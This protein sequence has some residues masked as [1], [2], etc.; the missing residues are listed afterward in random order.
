MEQDLKDLKLDIISPDAIVS[1]K[2]STGFYNKLQEV[3]Q[4]L[5]KGKSVKDMNEIYSQIK[6]Q[7]ITDDYVDSLQTMFILLKEF[8]TQANNEGHVS[9]MTKE[10][11]ETMIK[12][13]FPDRTPELK[14]I[15]EEFKRV[16]ENDEE[17]SAN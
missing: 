16:D 14:I 12:D 5:T 13:K 2:I 7:N 9:Q 10:E 4:Y 1:I 17:E 6:S 8:Q 15:D 11:A 3:V